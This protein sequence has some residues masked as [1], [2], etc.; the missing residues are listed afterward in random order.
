VQSRTTPH[1]VVRAT[2]G[3]WHG[4]ARGAGQHQ[5]QKSASVRRPRKP[6][7]V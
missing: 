1:R 5:A 6:M 2:R 4:G 7:G 3:K